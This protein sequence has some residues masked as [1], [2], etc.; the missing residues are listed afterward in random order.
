MFGRALC[1]RG[2]DGEKIS[3]GLAS[4]EMSSVL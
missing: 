1:G 2:A 4:P 3:L